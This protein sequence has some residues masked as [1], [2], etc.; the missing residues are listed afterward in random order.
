MNMKTLLAAVCALG[1]LLSANGAAAADNAVKIGVLS[2]MSGVYKSLEGPGAVIAARMAIDDFG[3]KVLGRPITLVSADHQ[4]KPD[5]ASSIARQWIDADHVTMITGLDNSGV[6]LAVQAVAAQ[7]KTIT[8]TAGAGATDLT[9]KQCT[10]YGI[11]YVYDTYSLPVGTATAIVK[12]GG[13][14]W[15]FITANYAFG[16][17]LQDNTAKVVKALGGTV[18]GS[19]DAPLST[20]DF[21]SYLLQ[22]QS[23]GAD[24]IALANAGNDT[25]NA[26]KQAREFGIISKGQQMAGLL[27]F[28]TDV[29]SMGLD[30]AQGLQFTSAFYWDR[31]PQSRAWSE[32]FYKL[33]GAMP[34]MVQAGVYSAVM[35][36]LKAVQ[37]V[38]TVDA[39]KVRAQLG[40]QKINDFFVHNGTIEPNGLMLHDMY[41]LKVKTPAESKGPW[42]LLKVVATIP[43]SK[44]FIPLAESQCPLLKM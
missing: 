27:V 10:P 9:E 39:D 42:D 24:V 12:N 31:T 35:D 43:A 26:M 37:A 5:V 28:I 1:T 20:N 11:H 17:S 19:V 34:T 38:G 6:A 2:D 30:V 4:N 3:G 21:S 8:M 15:F 18:V 29:K 7:K 23:S 32:R 14:K 33:H 41:L 36:Y 25:V 40:R 13:K 44:A 16:H 22:A